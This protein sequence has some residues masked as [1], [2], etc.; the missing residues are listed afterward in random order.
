MIFKCFLGILV[1]NDMSSIKDLT[2]LMNEF[3]NSKGWYNPDS[4]KPQTPKNIAL[5]L[6]IEATEVLE[7]FQWSE[8]YEK[9]ELQGELAD[10]ALYLIQLANLC[11]I[12]LEQAVKDKLKINYNRTWDK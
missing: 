3:V 9:K 7:H 11:D 2:L 1:C 4:K 10:V 6:V 12:D 5:S 8:N